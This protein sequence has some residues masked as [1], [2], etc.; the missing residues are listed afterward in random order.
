M[1]GDQTIVENGRVSLLFKNLLS[2]AAALSTAGI[3]AIFAIAWNLKDSI[4]ELDKTLGVAITKLEAKEHTDE[5]QDNDI[6]TLGTRVSELER[7]NRD[8]DRDDNN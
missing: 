6:A 7:R 3:L 2:I 5:R 8:D 4:H 1:A